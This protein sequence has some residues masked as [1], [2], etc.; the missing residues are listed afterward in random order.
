MLELFADAA[1]GSTGSEDLQS[2]V[3]IAAVG[4]LGTM[5]VAVVSAM[6]GRSLAARDR[7]REEYADAYKSAVE[8]R[9]MLHRVRRRTPS[10]EAALTER[11]HALHER[12]AFHEGWIGS[13]SRAMSIA[14]KKFQLSVRAETREDIRKAWGEDPARTTS[15]T[16][17]AG[18]DPV[19]DRSSDERFLLAVRRHLSWQPWRRAALIWSARK[20][21]N[22]N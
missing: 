1:S 14:F 9:E 19:P 3:L 5:L 12:I 18:G 7:R 10:D 21:Q 4:A 22:G 13:D 17:H 20:S 16:E 15:V 11:F 2:K 6:I 8:W